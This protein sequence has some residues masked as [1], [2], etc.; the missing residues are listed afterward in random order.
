MKYH[1]FL[2]FIACHMAV[3]SVLADEATVSFRSDI[4]PILQDRCL[5]CHS[6]K[7]AEG[8]YRVD[9]FEELLKAGDSGEV[10]ISTDPAGTSELLRRITCTDEFERMPAESDPL[11]TEQVAAIQTWIAQGAKFDG[12]DPAQ[13]LALVIPPPQY[14]APPEQYTRALPLT[15]LAVSP[16]GQQ[17]IAGGYHELTIWNPH[18]G[19]L[20]RRIPN[21]GQ[22]VFAIR[23]SPDQ[24]TLAVACGQPGRSGEVRLV[25]FATGEV[26]GVVAR[27]DDVVL[28]VAFRPGS[29]ELAVAAADSTIR[30][31]DTQTLEEV[32]SI[33]SHADWVTAVDWSDDG[34]VLV[35]A[36]RDKSAKVYDG[37]AGTLLASYLGHGSAVRGVK[38]L[39][40][41]AQVVS[42]GD[43]NKLHRW[44]IE[45]SK[46]LAE[47]P[48]GSAGYKLV[49]HGNTLLVPCANQRLLHVNLENNQIA[50]Q[51]QGHTAAVL[52]VAH[53]SGA[54]ADTTPPWIASGAFDGEIRLWKAGDAAL[55]HSWVAKP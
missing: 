41:N 16:D 33:A 52:S 49:R 40:D 5:A 3:G 48:L 21:V 9:S 54:D 45:E 6:A 34:K 42:V 11:S 47:V 31:V 50:Q 7:K 26:R 29:T 10:P 39:A 46:K 44:Q 15:A 23:F 36:S 13:V 24:K 25:D 32:R 1:R 2:L 17:L 51:F 35:S 19:T 18:E 37:T 55:L 38:V 12:A 30:I 4:A 8:G 28:D 20:V 43:D 27:T 53:W 22:R 14:A